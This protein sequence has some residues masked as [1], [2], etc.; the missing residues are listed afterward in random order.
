MAHVSSLKYGV[1]NVYI[2]QGLHAMHSTAQLN[3]GI[4]MS[5]HIRQMLEV[6]GHDA[7]VILADS[8]KNDKINSHNRLEWRYRHLLIGS[9]A[10]DVRVSMISMA[11]TRSYTRIH[12]EWII[13]FC[14]TL[15]IYCIIS[16]QIQLTMFTKRTNAFANEAQ[17][18]NW[19][20]H[21]GINKIATKSDC[22][23]TFSFFSE[24]WK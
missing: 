4:N 2:R 8:M 6:K 15:N 19:K 5:L 9:V 21:F 11:Y 18:N 22:A 12:K 14:S 23:N 7:T 24:T 3:G 1:W 20:M 16:D 10:I 13:T 17:T